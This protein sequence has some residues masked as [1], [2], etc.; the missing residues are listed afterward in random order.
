MASRAAACACAGPRPRP[1][2]PGLACSAP[3]AP[4]HAV[5][6]RA[7]RQAGLRARDRR[8]TAVVRPSPRP[9]EFSCQTSPFDLCRSCDGRAPRRACQLVSGMFWRVRARARRA[10]AVVRPS[11]RPAEFSCKTSPFALC[12][13]CDGRAPRR[14]RELVSWASEITWSTFLDARQS[15]KRRKANGRVW[16]EKSAG[17][18]KGRTTAVERRSRARALQKAYSDGIEAVTRVSC[19]DCSRTGIG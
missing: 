8:A 17:R 6:R 13:S 12:R 15:Q 1:P 5:R 2:P 16:Q 10:T 11:L 19:S 4:P 3:P 9:A 7:G 14:A 18:R